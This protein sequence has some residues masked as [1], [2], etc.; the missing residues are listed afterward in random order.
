V[1]FSGGKNAQNRLCEG[2]LEPPKPRRQIAALRAEKCHAIFRAK[3]SAK[4]LAG[5]PELEKAIDEPGTGNV[6]VIAEW[7]RVSIGVQN[8]P[9]IGAQ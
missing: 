5:R 1:H 7:D 3:A 8:R 6:L 2:Q 4:S 9:T